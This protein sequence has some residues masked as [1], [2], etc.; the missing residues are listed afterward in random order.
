MGKKKTAY[1]A[2]KRRFGDNRHTA[3]T[4][5]ENDVKT[6]PN[7]TKSG[8]RK[9]PSSSS[10]KVGPSKKHL[11]LSKVGLEGN[12][13]MDITLLDKFIATLLCPECYKDSSLSLSESFRYGLASKFVV[14]CTYNISFLPSFLIT[15]ASICYVGS[16][17]NNVIMSSSKCFVDQL[18]WCI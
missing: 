6:L 5:S 3:S 15:V 4:S 1:R 7:L 17:L 8:K 13:I 11:K 16:V 2:K 18:P 9:S 10:S 12:R 14:E